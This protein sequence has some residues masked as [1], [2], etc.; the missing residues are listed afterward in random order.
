MGLSASRA[1]GVGN[2]LKHCTLW[3]ADRSPACRAVMM[4]LD[5]LDLNI[6]EV[7]VNMDKGEHRSPEMIVMN[8]LQTLPILKDRNLILNDSNA[9]ATYMATRYWSPHASKLLPSDPGA[10]AMI[11]QFMFFNSNVL[12]PR[13]KEAAH[14]I[15]YKNCRYVP[16]NTM[17]DIQ[18][19]YADLEK[20]LQGRM[21]IGGS[22]P[23][24][25]DIMLIATVS[26]LNILVPIDQIEFPR[27]SSWV[28]R[29]SEEM[30]YTTANKKGLC[31][32]ARRLG[33]L[34]GVQ[35]TKD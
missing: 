15:L 26:T 31:E 1:S 30:F 23:S 9:I 11:D 19:A 16:P 3:K 25:G 27:V 5:A 32:F 18:C 20:M 29:M 17:C 2:N 21:F 10:R 14:P 24:M 4:A 6:N 34:T 13:Y 28:H 7:D 33:E 22:S 12:Y 35:S 8:P